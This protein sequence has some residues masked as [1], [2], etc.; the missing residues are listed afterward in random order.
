MTQ[1]NPI[2]SMDPV[3]TSIDLVRAVPG[4]DDYGS[5]TGTWEIVETIT[6]VD[7]YTEARRRAAQLPAGIYGIRS[8]YGKHPEQIWRQR[9]VSARQA[10]IDPYTT[11]VDLT[12]S[13]ELRGYMLTA[14][15]NAYERGDLVPAY[16]LSGWGRYNAALVPRPDVDGDTIG[17]VYEEWWGSYFA[18]IEIK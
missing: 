1:S 8:S 6:D 18:E 13:H 2:L 3:A 10:G 5:V 4:T 15:R 11:Q 17:L 16:P 7:P 12:D 9:I 14:I